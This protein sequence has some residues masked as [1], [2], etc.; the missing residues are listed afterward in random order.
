MSETTVLEATPRDVIGKANRRLKAA[1]QIPAVLYGHSREPLVLA[2]DRHDFEYMMQH[3]ATG[4]TI[5]KLNVEG[6]SKPFD[7]IIKDVQVSPVKGTVLHVDFL[8]IRM[9]E[10]IQATAPV[11][12]IGDAPGV[13]EGGVLL[14]DLREFS[15]EALPMSLPENIEVDVSGLELGHSLTVADVPAPEGVVILDDPET[16]VC[17]VSLPTVEVEEEPE[18]GAEMAEPALVGEDEDESAE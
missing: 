1:G 5:V 14:Q 2:V 8:A 4:A 12:F 11:H 3:H 16:V 15:V 6:E 13:K 17:S 18:E 7:A 9:D 10:V